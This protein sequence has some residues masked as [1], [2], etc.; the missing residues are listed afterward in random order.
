MEERKDIPIWIGVVGL[1]LVVASLFFDCTELKACIQQGI[2]VLGS[3]DYVVTM[4]TLM[5]AALYFMLGYKKNSAIYYKMFVWSYAVGMGVLVLLM[6]GKPLVFI[7]SSLIN[8]G[9]LF[10]LAVGKDLGK[11]RSYILC[12]LGLLLETLS[13]ILFIRIFGTQYISCM[14]SKVL[15]SILLLVMI[16]AKYADKDSRGTK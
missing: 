10:V 2:T 7:I 3:L 6:E 16:Y 5:F 8:Y 1:L 13:V 14:S 9:I 4:F 12:I 15:L 11:V